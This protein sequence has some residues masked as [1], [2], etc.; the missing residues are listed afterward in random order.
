MFNLEYSMELGAVNEIIGSIG[1][2][3]VNTL[4]GEAN[5]DVVTARRLLYNAN[6]EVQ[7]KGWTFNIEQGV[8]LFPDVFSKLIAY[9]SDILNMRSS[10][11]ATPYV[12]I[13]GYV[14]DRINRVDRFEGPIVV[15]II[16]MRQLDEMPECFKRWIVLKASVKFAQAS[17]GDPDT[18]RLLM[19]DVEQA[20]QDCN[21]YELD[22]GNYNALTGD[23][24]ITQ[25]LNRG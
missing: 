23:T 15:D 1:E 4:D 17:F 9:D 19:S 2:P 11:T 18:V 25:M 8:S 12:N 7:S 24:Y 20:R 3:P 10:Q 22:Y 13:E 6:R 14:Y 21:E 16:R 5:A